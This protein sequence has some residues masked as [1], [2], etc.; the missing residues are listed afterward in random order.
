M[1]F[2]NNSCRA[3]Y[4][5]K[6]HRSTLSPGSL[7]LFVFTCHRCPQNVL[8]CSVY[9]YKKYRSDTLN[10]IW[11]V[12]PSVIYSLVVHNPVICIDPFLVQSVEKMLPRRLGITLRTVWLFS[13]CIALLS[14][15]NIAPDS[16]LFYLHEAL[17]FAPINVPISL[18]V[19]A[20]LVVGLQF[21][22]VAHYQSIRFSRVMVFI[23]LILLGVKAIASLGLV[24]ATWVRQNLKSPALGLVR[25]LVQMHSSPEAPINGTPGATFNAFIRSPSPLPPK[26]VLMLIESWG[27]RPDTL[28]QISVNLQGRRLQL[29]GS[30]FTTYLGSTLSGEFR[31]LCSRYL[32]PSGGLKD[33]SVQ[34][35]CAPAFLRDRGYR[36][37][38]LHGYQKAFYARSIFWNRFGISDQLFSDDLRGLERCSGAFEGICDNALIKR[39]IG[40]LHRDEG[41]SFV[42]MLTLT[43]HEPLDPS[44]LV[45]STGIFGAIE[46]VHPNQVV[47][48][49]A[50]SDLV[51]DLERDLE[52]PCTLVYIASDHQPPS[53]SSQSGIFQNNQVPFLAFTRNCPT[54]AR[55]SIR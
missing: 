26:I 24:D 50:I 8:S 51:V 31:E 17:P 49:R 13:F 44:S 43:G 19:V 36:T 46:V 54:A 14:A 15:W 25:T 35:D 34:L 42:Y 23:G 53:A 45:Q 22:G 6:C 20:L 21:F 48:R 39:G 30:G 38:G 2:F 11:V 33:E 10:V 18:T 7:G 3:L 1:L 12:I 4:H 28:R 52:Q 40:L 16:Y 9:M 5:V 47:S 29:I 32:L 41:P 37:F 55:N 27:E